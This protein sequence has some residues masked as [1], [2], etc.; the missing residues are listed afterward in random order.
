MLLCSSL[1]SLYIFFLSQVYVLNTNALPQSQSEQ[2]EKRGVS[3]INVL[4]L[5]L[6]CRNIVGIEMT[7]I[8]IELR[9]RNGDKNSD[10]VGRDNERWRNMRR[11]KG[12]MVDKK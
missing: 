12:E 2:D 11:L 10:R 6:F 7:E 9:I 1:T 3:K 8:E 4:D 5:P